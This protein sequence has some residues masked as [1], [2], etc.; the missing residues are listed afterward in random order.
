[1]VRRA[2]GKTQDPGQDRERAGQRDEAV[3]PQLQRHLMTLLPVLIA[4]CQPGRWL[5]LCSLC[6]KRGWARSDN[7]LKVAG[8]ADGGRSQANSHLPIVFITT[9]WHPAAVFCRVE[10]S[11]GS[12]LTHKE[13]ATWRCEVW[14]WGMTSCGCFRVCAAWYLLEASSQ[15]MVRG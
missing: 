13:V 1:M 15:G 8:V 4:R 9:V 5:A 11:H 14:S 2:P 10:V 6:R 12:C 7:L 3:Y